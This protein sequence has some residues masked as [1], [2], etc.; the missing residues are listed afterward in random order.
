MKRIQPIILAAG[1][2]TRLRELVSDRPKPLADIGGRPFITYLFDQIKEARFKKIVICT[3][4]MANKFPEMLGKQYR[5]MQLIY[6][7]ENHPTGVGGALKNAFKHIDSKYALIM[8]GDTLV[9]VDLGRYVQDFLS[10]EKAISVAVSKNRN[11]GVYI[12]PTKFVAELYHEEPCHVYE[13]GGYLDIGTVETFKI[14]QEVLK[15]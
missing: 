13:V 3:A 11:A 1:Y 4:Y 10:S 8:N 6:S 7:K 5:G 9:D 14:A 2:G 12:I 15:S